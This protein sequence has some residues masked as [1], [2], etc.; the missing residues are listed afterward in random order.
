MIDEIYGINNYYRFNVTNYINQWLVTVGTE[1]NGF[2]LIQQSAVAR[3][4]DRLVLD[5]AAGKDAGVLLLLHVLN[6]NN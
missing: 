5:A 1:K 4:M 6:I 3:S 2:F